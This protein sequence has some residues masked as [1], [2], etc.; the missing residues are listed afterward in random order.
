MEVLNLLLQQVIN[1]LVPTLDYF[2][3]PKFRVEFNGRCLKP[4]R[5]TF[6][7]EKINEFVYYL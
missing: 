1:S 6:P 7:P 4:D 5:V 2:N 3:N